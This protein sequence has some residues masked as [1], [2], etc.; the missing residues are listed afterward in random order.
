M[1]LPG[2]VGRQREIAAL[3]DELDH[4][5]KTGRGAFV[6]VR[7]RRRVGKSWLAE[8]F[9]LREHLPHVFF[10]ASR[11]P[12]DGDLG[13]FAS[14]LS[15]SSLPESARSPGVTF[16]DWES[17]LVTA[18]NGAD[19][20]SPSIIIIDEFPYLGGDDDEQAKAVESLFSAAWERRLSRQPVVLLIVGSDLTMMERLTEY[21]RPL[22]D[23]P[24]R[25]LVLDPLSLADIAEITGLSPED[26]IDTYAITGGLPAFA[27]ARRDA[28]SLSAFLLSALA[29]A[30][31]PF[32]NAAVRILD[33]EFPSHLQARSI[34]SAI[35][36]G[37]R[38][39][40]A[41]SAATGTTTG[42]LRGPLEL[43]SD[44]KRIVRIARPYATESL[45]APRFS[46]ADPY[47]RFWLR[48][49]ERELPAIG[50]LRTEEVVTRILV[51]WPDVRGRLVEPIIRDA[52]ERLLPDDQ[53]PGASHVG[54]YWNRKGDLEVDLVGGDRLQA[55]TKVSFVGSIKW[56]DRKPFASGD[57]EELIEGA[58][59]V[60]GVGPATPLV[61]ISR[62]GVD[63]S[64]RKLSVAVAAADLVGASGNA[65]AGSPR[66]RSPSH[67][68]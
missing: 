8:E 66:A 53:L 55:P 14:A 29:S 65:L 24:T 36:Y 13:R 63:R 62:S 28:G 46:V 2:F 26:V 9:V 27:L 42:N 38:T 41:I 22:Y 6:L 30:D 25:T 5:R 48:F 44:V 60:P 34:L 16:R 31:T 20:A 19:Q 50:R 33:A 57:L 15:E 64:A 17:A 47:L 67:A 32:V 11:N 21:G 45:S 54:S 61:A 40:R 23:R 56:R 35:G 7:G 39:R 12:V 10:T 37:E 43:L 52:L 1:V 4:V 3:T 51:Q 68:D 49:V 58:A 18:A 59:R